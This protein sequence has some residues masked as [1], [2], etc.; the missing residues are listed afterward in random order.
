MLS[1]G[2]RG[3]GPIILR[4]PTWPRPLASPLPTPG[5]RKAFLQKERTRPQKEYREKDRQACEPLRPANPLTSQLQEPITAL[6][7][8]N[9]SLPLPNITTTLGLAPS[10]G[11]TREF[12]LDFSKAF[13]G[14]HCT[15]SAAPFLNG[16]SSLRLPSPKYTA[17]ASLMHVAWSGLSPMVQQ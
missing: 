12:T 7:S 3:Q 11:R 9:N 4:P 13:F 17:G 6:C 1:P 15:L 8:L 2:S 16:T 14:K 10:S 5:T